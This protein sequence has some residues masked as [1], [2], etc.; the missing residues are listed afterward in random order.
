M[1]SITQLAF[2]EDKTKLDSTENQ[3]N[4]IDFD[5]E[6]DMKVSLNGNYIIGS[7]NF[8]NNETSIG[9]QIFYGRGHNTLYMNYHTLNVFLGVGLDL[10]YSKFKLIDSKSGQL[11]DESYFRTL[12][13]GELTF[14][15]L[16]FQF[17][18]GPAF[19]VSGTANNYF[20]MI[21]S[22]GPYIP[23]K[24]FSIQ[25]LARKEMDDSRNALLFMTGL[26]HHIFKQGS[27]NQSPYNSI[28][29][30]KNH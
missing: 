27:F 4:I 12:V 22:G 13:V 14:W 29:F 23:L 26:T 15:I 2:S 3:F 20:S 5:F 24:R 9:G 17:G 7:S 8:V 11:Y 21:L 30:F 19:G 25:I 10:S 28:H 6:Y 1:I 18:I 16:T